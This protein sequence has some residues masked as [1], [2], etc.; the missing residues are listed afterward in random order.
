MS[1]LI[2]IDRTPNDA[3]EPAEI[4]LP[5]GTL[6]L[7]SAGGLAWYKIPHGEMAPAGSR[8]PTADELSG[9]RLEL[10]AVVSLKQSAR[11]RIEREVGD[12]HEIIADQARQIEALTALGAR[13]AADYL[14]GTQMDAETKASYLARVESIVSALDS[15]ALTLRGEAGGPDDMLAKT[16]DRANRINRII[17]EEYLPRR[18]KLL[19]E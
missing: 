19:E 15:G 3:D 10:P 17:A 11:R 14:G 13:M 1:Q 16:L 8:A 9:A 5:E 12:V 6:D 4:Q 18:R 2:V 7:G